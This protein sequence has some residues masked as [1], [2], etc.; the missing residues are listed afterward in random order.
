MILTPQP[1]WFW[2]VCEY[3]THVGLHSD[4]H[5]NR[6]EELRICLVTSLPSR[7]YDTL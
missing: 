7:M 6:F 1:F 4:L 3:L 2:Y 5:F